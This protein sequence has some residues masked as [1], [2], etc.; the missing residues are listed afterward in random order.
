MNKRIFRGAYFLKEHALWTSH[1]DLL[2]FGVTINSS[3]NEAISRSRRE[4]NN[5]SKVTSSSFN[6]MNEV[7]ICPPNIMC[8]ALFAG[9]SCGRCDLADTNNL[10]TNKIII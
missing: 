10:I 3:F 5:S 2:V 1:R 8:P 9:R 6:N 7:L 4:S